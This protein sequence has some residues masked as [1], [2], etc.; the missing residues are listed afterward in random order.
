MFSGIPIKAVKT[1]ILTRCN[2]GEF[3]VPRQ[4]RVKQ[5]KG[6]G[7]QKTSYLHPNTCDGRYLSP[8]A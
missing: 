3:S 5:K 7:Q 2:A 8:Y 1:A 4:A 6:L